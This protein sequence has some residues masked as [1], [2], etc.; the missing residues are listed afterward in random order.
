MNTYKRYIRDNFKI[1]C[2]CRLYLKKVKFYKLWRKQN[3]HNKTE[4]GNLFN[5]KCVEVGKNTYGVINLLNYNEN[6][7][8]RIGSFCSIGP[9]VTFVLSGEHNVNT[10]TTYPIKASYENVKESLTKGNIIL[11]DD[12]WIGCNTT[13]L[14][15]V[16][17]GQ[18]A[19]VGAGS[20]V[21][22]DVPPYAIVGGVPA[23]VI[24]FRFNAELIE[25]LLKVDY[26][27]LDKEMITH[28]VDDLY[29]TLKSVDQ[30]NWM[31]KKE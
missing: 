19:V 29:Q 12:I 13:I 26:S 23:K 25:E 16:K 14:S 17:I 7:K 4:P 9:N 3:I 11:E 24:K 10:L 6:A 1:L 21:N 31:P 30:I 5:P 20:L 22:K 8:L 27:K 18:G 28:H 2:D 15:G